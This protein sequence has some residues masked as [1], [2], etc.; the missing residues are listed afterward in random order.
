MKYIGL[1]LTV[2]LIGCGNES[3]SLNQSEYYCTSM[4]TY[5]EVVPGRYG[6]STTYIVSNDKCI[7]TRKNSV[8]KSVYI[9]QIKLQELSKEQ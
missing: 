9:N 1:L 7:F 3:V 4:S 2:L 8:E 5:E 6:T